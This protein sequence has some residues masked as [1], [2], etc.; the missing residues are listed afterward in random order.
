M[1]YTG[2]YAICGSCESLCMKYLLVL[3]FH[4]CISNKETM[5]IICKTQFVFSTV[6]CIINVLVGDL[7]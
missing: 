6:F 5:R 4:T 1:P 2:G 7:K 3:K